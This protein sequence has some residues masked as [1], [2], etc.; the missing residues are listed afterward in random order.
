M[1]I[2]FMNNFALSV[3]GRQLKKKKLQAQQTLI[4]AL[5]LISSKI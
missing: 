2:D 5:K 4:E 3:A 1:Q